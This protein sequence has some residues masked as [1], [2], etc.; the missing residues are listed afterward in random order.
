[1][2]NREQP[3]DFQPKEDRSFLTQL[4]QNWFLI[5]ILLLIAGG[6][7][8][9]LRPPPPMPLPPAVSSQ[10]KVP[11]SAYEL[12]NF[13]VISETGNVS[14]LY[15]Y[16][17]RPKI[18]V[19]YPLECDECMRSLQTLDGIAKELRGRVDIFAIAIARRP[20]D[21]TELIQKSYEKQGITDLKAF[22]ISEAESQGLFNQSA[23]LPHS[24]VLM[25]D[26][27]VAREINGPVNWNDAV[28]FQ[29]IEQL[30]QLDATNN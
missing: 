24:Y 13:S 4:R 2:R 22:T 27:F 12:R 15:S 10:W 25:K 23:P 18:V 17:G 28:L 3:L 14:R 20:G 30:E 11:S 29:L 26:N 6:T 9:Y 19:G 21:L 7:Y 5:V 1:V 8:F 16:Y